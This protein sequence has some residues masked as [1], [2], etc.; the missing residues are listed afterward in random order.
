MRQT[1]RESRVVRSGRGAA[2]RMD[3]RGRLERGTKLEAQV[4]A[5]GDP[6][7]IHRA[8]VMAREASGRCK[9]S[10]W[11]VSQECSSCPMDGIRGC[12]FILR[13]RPLAA[14]PPSP[15][16][17]NLSPNRANNG[18]KYHEKE[19][20]FEEAPGCGPVPVPGAVLFDLKGWIVLW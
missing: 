3:F 11:V 16:Q 20:H 8:R 2:G 17:T 4:D 18:G 7:V 9:T 13:H 19:Q 10:I 5:D 6:P 15:T 1:Q 12:F 14:A